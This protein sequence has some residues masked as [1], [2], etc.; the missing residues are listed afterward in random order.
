MTVVDLSANVRG[1]VNADELTAHSLPAGPLA[2]YGG[3]RELARLSGITTTSLS[4]WL[5]G[6]LIRADRADRLAVA[7]G[8]H[9]CQIWGEDW[10]NIGT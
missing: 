2:V 8:K 4:R 3:T 1:P 7:L 6:G 5:E 9:P 10:W